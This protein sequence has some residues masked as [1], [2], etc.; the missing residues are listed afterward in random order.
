M[1]QIRPEERDD[2]RMIE[3]V[4]ARNFGPGRTAKSAYRL[5]EGVA[6]EAG[7]GFVAIEDGILKGSVRFWPI[8]VGRE[9]ALLLGPLTVETKERGRG[10]GLA[11][12]QRG[13]EEARAHR[14]RAILLVGDAVY[15]S[16]VGFA[17][18]PE[19]RPQGIAHALQ[20]RR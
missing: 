10:I 16:R 13:I 8:A 4:V 5:R 19:G 18:V 2:A 11:L 7:L 17:P 20:R 14:H 1:W 12:M 15:Y 6:P 9:R 3:A